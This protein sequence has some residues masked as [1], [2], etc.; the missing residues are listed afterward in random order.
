[1]L[2]T[3][4]SSFFRPF[5]IL[6][7]IEKSIEA[8]FSSIDLNLC[9]Y[10]DNVLYFSER[11]FYIKEI[12]KR[13]ADGGAA[14]HQTHAPFPSYQEGEEDYNKLLKERT[15][16]AIE[17]SAELGAK[18]VIVHPIWF[19]NDTPAVQMEKNLAL[20]APYG[21]MAKK[22]GIKIAIE[23]MWGH[24]RD[25]NDRIIKNVCSDAEELC[26]Y[27]AALGD[28]Y[29]ICLDLGH[30]GLVGEAADEM[31]LAIG[32]E[33][34]GALHVHDNDFYHDTHTAPFYGDMNWDAITSA[35]AAID[36]DESFTF[37]VDGT[38]MPPVK[39]LRLPAAKYLFEIG[40]YLIGEIERK[41]NK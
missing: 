31:I 20:Y 29:T 11:D 14:I 19:R 13:L 16:Q 41:K 26:T 27:L 32:K 35:L 1:M 37:E 7:E 15:L 2:L 5:G 25:K 39:E 12:K 9:L 30:A 34:L 40:N 6:G 8:G 24:H 38:F 36:Y 28:G 21:E 22:C 33:R 4:N 18:Q 3:I 23:N 17:I 10:N